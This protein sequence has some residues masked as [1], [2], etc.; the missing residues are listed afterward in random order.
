MLDYEVTT[1]VP[2]DKYFSRKYDSKKLRWDLLPLGPVEKVVRILTHGAKKYSANS[3]Q[4]V[5][6]GKERYYAAAMRHLAA[7]RAG[8]KKDSASR[9]PH[10]AHAACNLIFLMWLDDEKKHR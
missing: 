1:F 5:P 2:Q 3:W 9:L 7:W 4:S 8:K 6:N 10:L